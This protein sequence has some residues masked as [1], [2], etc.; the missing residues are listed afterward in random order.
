MTAPI[1]HVADPDSA[2]RTAPRPLRGGG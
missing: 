2:S 1:R